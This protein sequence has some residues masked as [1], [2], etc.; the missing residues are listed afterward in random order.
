[1]KMTVAAAGL[2]S[3]QRIL[4][5]EKEFPFSWPP[6]TGEN[7]LLSHKSQQT[8]AVASLPQVVGLSAARPRFNSV[9]ACL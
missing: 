4:Q 2:T 8:G 7:L 6:L 5:R 3:S 9:R 1:M